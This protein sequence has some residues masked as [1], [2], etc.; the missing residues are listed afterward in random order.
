MHT[1]EAGT[2][3][4]APSPVPGRRFAV[5]VARFNAEITD[6]LLESC[7]EGLADHGVEADGIDVLRVPG[8][9]E[10]PQTVLCA[11]KTGRYDAVIALG[12]VIRGETAHFDF[13]AG[14]AAYGLGAAARGLDVPVIFGVLTTDTV[15]QAMERAGPDRGDKGREFAL[16]ALH[17]VELYE[18]LCE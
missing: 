18:G 10:L 9:W 5:V 1:P 4:P 14:E 6:L 12:C 11:G 8:A 2:H 3:L 13:V 15:E 16:S 17:M 7:L